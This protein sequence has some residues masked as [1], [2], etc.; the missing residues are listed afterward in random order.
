MLPSNDPVGQHVVYVS[1]Y[2]LT[3]AA[4]FKLVNPL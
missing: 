1:Y 4:D 3:F 2:R